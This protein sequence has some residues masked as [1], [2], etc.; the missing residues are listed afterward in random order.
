MFFRHPR[1]EVRMSGNNRAEFFIHIT[2]K[3]P[4][5]I[6]GV[7]NGILKTYSPKAADAAA[8]KSAEF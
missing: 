1:F 4:Q 2:K 6:A 8:S 5:D 3:L 7:Q